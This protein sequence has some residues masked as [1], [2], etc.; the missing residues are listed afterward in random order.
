MSRDPYMLSPESNLW[1]AAS[2]SSAIWNDMD[3]ALRRVD[4]EWSAAS[5]CF[6]AISHVSVPVPTKARK[7]RR[8]A[9]R[10]ST[11]FLCPGWRG[12]QDNSSPNGVRYY[13]RRGRKS[14]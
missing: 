13:I 10:I 14:A 8:K 5:R 4:R 9:L 12:Q 11:R 2:I 7:M 3:L 6:W 1:R